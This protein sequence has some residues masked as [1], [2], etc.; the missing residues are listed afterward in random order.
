MCSLGSW[1]PCLCGE[2]SQKLGVPTSLFR[3][4]CTE[5]E[6]CLE[7]YILA[8]TLNSNHLPPFPVST[9]LSHVFAEEKTLRR[10]SSRSKLFGMQVSS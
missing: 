6:V 2:K 8:R 10:L 4:A 1:L 5:N 7:K 3:T 9:F